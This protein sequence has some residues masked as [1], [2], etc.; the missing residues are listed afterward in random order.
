[1]IDIALL[2]Q[3][4]WI[5]VWLSRKNSQDA[6]VYGGGIVSAGYVA[7]QTTGWVSN[8]MTSPSNAAFLWLEQH[9]TS[10]T[11]AVAILS[12]FLPPQPVTTTLSQTR[13][14]SLH[15]ARTLIF[16]TITIAVFL[17]FSIIT[18]LRRAIWDNPSHSAHAAEERSGVTSLVALLCSMYACII[19]LMF[20]SDVAWVGPF[21]LLAPYIRQ[22]LAMHTYAVLLHLMQS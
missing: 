3:L 15:V 10:G 11:Q 14:I 22:S 17:T 12:Q 13:F 7:W 19:S 8:L 4:T 5:F 18:L 9:M 6:L 21:H 1:M 20:I 16:C 2:V